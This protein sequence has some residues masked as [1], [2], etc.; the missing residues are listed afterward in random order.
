M[1]APFDLSLFDNAELDVLG[2]RCEAL[3]KRLQ[4]MREERHAP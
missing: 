1:N 3:S 2:K 4:G